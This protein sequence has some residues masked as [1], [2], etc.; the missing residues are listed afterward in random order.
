MSVPYTHDGSHY[1]RWGRS[2]LDGK[3]LVPAF[4]AYDRTTQVHVVSAVLV[5]HV[6]VVMWSNS[7]RQKIPHATP[8]PRFYT[9]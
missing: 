5:E 9:I 3:K 1:M 6:G 7:A 2:G 4:L 8:T